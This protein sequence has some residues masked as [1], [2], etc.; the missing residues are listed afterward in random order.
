MK[1]VLLTGFEPFLIYDYNPSGEL[2]KKFDGK[3]IGNATIIGKVLPVKHRESALL[4]QKYVKKE[5]P[6]VLISLGMSNQRGSIALERVALNRYYFTSDE[7]EIDIP[8]YDNGKEAYFSTLPLQEIKTALIKE[9]IPAEYSFWPD[10][11]VSN[12][13]FYEAMKLAN[14]IGIHKAGFIHV[15]VEHKQ[16]AHARKLHYA[17]RL[18]APSMSAETLEKST[19]IIIKEAAK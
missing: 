14:E 15:P 4:L 19:S 16:V 18:A 6:D 5:K 2:A 10:T 12:E 13:I 1:K 3:K 8:L 7:K 17:T 11:F 9:D